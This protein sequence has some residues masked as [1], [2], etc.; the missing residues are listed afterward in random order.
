MDNETIGDPGNNGQDGL[1]LTDIVLL[2]F[3]AVAAMSAFASIVSITY[4]KK[5]IRVIPQ[6][7]D[8]VFIVSP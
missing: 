7:R 2:I 6:E 8:E 3:G 5:N 4:N 1:G